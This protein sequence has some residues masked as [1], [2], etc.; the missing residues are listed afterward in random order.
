MSIEFQLWWKN[1]LSE[2]WP[3]KDTP[4]LALA[5]KLWGVCCDDLG[6]NWP[7]Y[8]GTGKLWGVCCD[9][10]GENWPHYNGTGKLW[11]VCCDDLGEN[12]PHYNGTALYY[13]NYCS[14]VCYV[15][16]SKDSFL[17]FW[18]FA[19][20]KLMSSPVSHALCYVSLVASGSLSYNISSACYISNACRFYTVQNVV[21]CILI[22]WA[23]D[24]L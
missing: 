13:F 1:C 18:N 4:Y 11:G 20:G 7:H 8:N 23:T 21:Y 5:G 14:A 10:L 15:L 12:W 9:D 3:T 16:T 17:V 22:E 2:S 24:S 19:H 6:E